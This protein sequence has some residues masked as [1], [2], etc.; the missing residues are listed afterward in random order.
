MASEFVGVSM[1]Y[2]Y[3]L[4]YKQL[5]KRYN[6]YGFYRLPENDE[7]DLHNR[8]K[9]RYDASCKFMFMPLD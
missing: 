3:A 9:P 6:E 7:D 1:V 4:P 2:I 8:L 5:I